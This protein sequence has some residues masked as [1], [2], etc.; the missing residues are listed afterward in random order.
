MNSEQSKQAEQ[1]EQSGLFEQFFL[2]L[3]LKMQAYGLTASFVRC[4][5]TF[6]NGCSK[7]KVCSCKSPWDNFLWDLL[8]NEPEVSPYLKE[9]CFKKIENGF[10]I[11]NEQWLSLEKNYPG[12]FTRVV[13]D[14]KKFFTLSSLSSANEVYRISHDQGLFEAASV[15]CE[16]YASRGPGNFFANHCRVIR[17]R[18]LEDLLRKDKP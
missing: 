15:V 8:E 11:T 10:E 4:L 16:K 1:T 14:G 17:F 9:L 13:I 6:G 18:E 3:F 2:A 7:C 12:V 5:P